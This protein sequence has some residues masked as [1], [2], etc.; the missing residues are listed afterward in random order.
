M[1]GGLGNFEMPDHKP[2]PECDNPLMPHPGIHRRNETD[3]AIDGRGY[4]F[5]IALYCQFCLY[6]ETTVETVEIE[7]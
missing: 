4:D 7:E 3:V 2:C 5:I 1:M 6:T